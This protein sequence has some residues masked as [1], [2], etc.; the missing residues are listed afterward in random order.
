MC[1]GEEIRKSISASQ[2]R[3]AFEV[4]ICIRGQDE[5]RNISET[6][7][8]DFLYSYIRGIGRKRRSKTGGGRRDGTGRYGSNKKWFGGR[9]MIQVEGC[10]ERI[11][12]PLA[13]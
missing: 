7:T 3:N 11:N 4:R 6:R 10:R 9:A 13:I 2:G 5:V 8:D 12:K 1:Q